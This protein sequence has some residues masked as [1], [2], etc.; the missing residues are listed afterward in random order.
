MYVR[1][2]ARLPVLGLSP[3]ERTRRL[4]GIASTQMLLKHTAVLFMVVRETDYTNNGTHSRDP[5]LLLL[6]YYC[7]TIVLLPSTF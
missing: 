3:F 1:T 7:T 5:Y 4:S 6:Y 2:G